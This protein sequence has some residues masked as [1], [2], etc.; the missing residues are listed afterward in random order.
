MTPSDF[1]FWD[2]GAKAPL[3]TALGVQLER[4]LNP[5]KRSLL[6][7]GNVKT[8]PIKILHRIEPSMMRRNLCWPELLYLE[9]ESICPRL[10][11]EIS[12]EVVPVI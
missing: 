10:G 8:V 2:V 9:R 1:C 3:D 7:K 5:N 11:Q 12:I 4:K 6:T